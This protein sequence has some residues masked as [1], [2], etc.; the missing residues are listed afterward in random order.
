MAS[1]HQQAGL[2]RVQTCVAG[3]RSTIRLGR[4]RQRD[5]EYA[6]ECIEAL[7]SSRRTGK[8]VPPAIEE[9][10]HRSGEKL[11]ARLVLAGLV[12]PRSEEKP[13][14]VGELCT[15]F[16]GATTIKPVTAGKY[17]VVC[18][19]LK[20]LLGEG[21]RVDTVRPTDASDVR[22][23]WVKSG[24]AGPT[25]AKRVKVARGVFRLAVKLELIRSNPFEAVRAG[26]MT[27]RS[28]MAFVG[29]DTVDKIL[30]ACPDDEW[31]LIVALSRFGGMRVPSEALLLRWADVNWSAGSMIVRSPKTE[32]YA[33]GAERVCPIFPE[34]LPFMLKVFNAAPD[35]AEHVITRYRAGQ[36]L[37]PQFH[38]IIRRAGLAAWPRVWHSMRAT[39]QTELVGEFPLHEV[40]AWLGNSERVARD[41]YLQSTDAV[42]ERARNTPTGTL[43]GAGGKSDVKSDAD[44]TRQGTPD[45]DTEEPEPAFAASERDI[46]RHSTTPN[47][48]LMAP[49]G[50]E[51]TRRLRGCGF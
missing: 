46:D 38:R 28:R 8:P 35:R 43:P 3:K 47:T 1:L 22:A 49:V 32:H 13:M 44:T 37:N 20:E 23:A 30:A 21:R 36:N 50:V 5:A 51:P 25:V 12:A 27:N 39:R 7:E 18:R 24:L 6:H 31:R 34:L 40:C 17:D 48:T 26:S 9:W 41:H 11:H 10:V 29:R 19:S 42:F 2:W 33:G 14:T 15:R 16:V 45:R 4:V